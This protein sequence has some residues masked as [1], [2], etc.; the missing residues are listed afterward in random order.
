MYQRFLDPNDNRAKNITITINGIEIHKWDPFV[1]DEKETELLAEETVDVE[2]PDGKETSFTLKA[3]MI[4]RRGTY[5]TPQAQESARVNNDMQGFYVYRENRLI[6]S[7]DWFGMFTKEPHFS[8]LRIEFSFDYTLDSTFDIDIKKSRII[9]ADKIFDYIKNNFTSAPRR[10]AEE[11][12]RDGTKKQVSGKT[13]ASDAHSASNTN[14]DKNAAKAQESNVTVT[15]KDEIEIQ[16]KN[17]TFRHKITIKSQEKPGQVRVIPVETLDA[18]QLW[19]PCIVDGKK[20]VQINMSH[21]Y[22]QKV[23]YPV[24]NQSV[25]VTGMDALLWAL[26][27]AEHGTYNEETREYYEEMRIMVS[28]ILKKLLV[29]LPEPDNEDE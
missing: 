18:N 3:Y 28:N 26:S 21:P 20:A 29:D 2:L 17:G 7:G 15:G 11:R 25:M 19:S 24:I 8:L 23:Y 9:I 4:P 14:I 12:Y 22:Y 10:A 27:E 6:H 5:S 13:N 1:T 16:N